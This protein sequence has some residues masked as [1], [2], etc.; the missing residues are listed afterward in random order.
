M[1]CLDILIE[2]IEL[3]RGI[4][5]PR[6]GPDMYR[7]FSAL[8]DFGAQ[9]NPSLLYSSNVQIPLMNHV[10][11]FAERKLSHTRVYLMAL[12]PVG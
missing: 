8:A 11:D 6:W 3:Y 1:T 9:I 2:S 7:S 5:L 4:R 12:T 10:S